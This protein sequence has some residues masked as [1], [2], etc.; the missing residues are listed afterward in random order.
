MKYLL[1]VIALLGIVF[2]VI[3]SQSS[4]MAGAEDPYYIEMRLDIEKSDVQ[5]VGFGKMISFE[6]CKRHAFTLWMKSL[7]ALGKASFSSECKKELPA[8]YLKLFENKQANAS[9]VAFDKGSDDE[10]DGRFLIYGVPSSLVFQECETI[11]R[12][13]ARNYSGEVYCIKGGVG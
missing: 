9:Y 6:D 8:K 12:E 1:L 10:R 7:E 13:V 4:F 5:L 2:F 11:T 3:N